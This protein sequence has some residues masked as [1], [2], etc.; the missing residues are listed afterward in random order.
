MDTQFESE[1]IHKRKNKRVKKK[2][3]DEVL[4]SLKVLEKPL[5]LR[6][7]EDKQLNVWVKLITIDTYKTFYK[8]VLVSSG[9]TSSYIS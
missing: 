9:S 7:M 3:N 6:K 4:L 5:I 2:M 8:Q 1:R